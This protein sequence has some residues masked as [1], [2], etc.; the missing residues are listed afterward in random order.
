MTNARQRAGTKHHYA[1]AWQGG[2]HQYFMNKDDFV[3]NNSFPSV[4]PSALGS[5]SEIP[6]QNTPIIDT[7]TGAITGYET[8]T[9]KPW[10]SNDKYG[11]KGGTVTSNG[12]IYIGRQGA[13]FTLFVDPNERKSYIHSNAGQDVASSKTSAMVST[14][15]TPTRSSFPLNAQRLRGEGVLERPPTTFGQA[16]ADNPR[17]KA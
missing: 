10:P 7:S 4:V 5:W 11:W 13:M 15:M 12:K 9:P 1:Y 3:G 2:S 17:R 8:F 16:A 6:I 14:R